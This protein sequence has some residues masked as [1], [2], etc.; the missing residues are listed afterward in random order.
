MKHNFW[1]EEGNWIENQKTQIQTFGSL[2]SVSWAHHEGYKENWSRIRAV[3]GS[4]KK[5]NT[6]KGL[7]LTFHIGMLGRKVNQP[8]KI[9]KK[10]YLVTLKKEKKKKDWTGKAK[11]SEL[12]LVEC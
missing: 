9:G 4:L 10:F 6:M 8:G 11:S 7:S 3:S 12:C 1:Q 2:T 5:R